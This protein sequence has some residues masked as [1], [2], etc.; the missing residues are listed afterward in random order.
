[1]SRKL[2][3]IDKLRTTAWNGKYKEDCTDDAVFIH[4]GKTMPVDAFFGWTTAVHSSFP[5]WQWKNTFVQELADGTIKIGSQ[6]TTGKLVADIP[7]IGPFPQVQLSQ[8]PSDSLLLTDKGCSLPVEVGVY[9][10][11]QD[12]KVTKIEYSGELGDTSMANTM[13]FEPCVGPPLLY[14][15]AGKPI[16]PPA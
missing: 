15:V 14:A 3:I 13:Q 2:A 12:M 1:M 9:T 16:A 8:V 6:Q 10:F 5:H 4:G 7:A 11:N